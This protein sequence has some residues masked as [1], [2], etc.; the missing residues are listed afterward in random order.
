MTLPIIDLRQIPDEKREA[1]AHL[2]AT[3]EAHQPFDLANGPILRLLLLRL[4]DREHLLIWNM[5]CIVCDGA[6]S[7]IFY[8]DFT[9]IYKALSVG[10]ASP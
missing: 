4:S 3:K 8:Q 5:H 9:T 2:L 10:K 7:D 1:E 6:S